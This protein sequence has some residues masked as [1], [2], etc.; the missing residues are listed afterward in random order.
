MAFSEGIEVDFTF[1]VADAEGELHTGKPK[2]FPVD[3]VSDDVASSKELKEKAEVEKKEVEKKEAEMKDAAQ[4]LK[5]VIIIS[6]VIVVVAATIFAVT[7][8]LKET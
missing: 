7:K 2:N 8:K 4:T 1:P 3:P 5:S 6:S